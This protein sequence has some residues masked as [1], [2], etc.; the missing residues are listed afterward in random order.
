MS[1]PQRIFFFLPAAPP[2]PGLWDVKVQKEEP[3]N[4]ITFPPLNL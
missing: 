2:D 1:F 4:V 3:K